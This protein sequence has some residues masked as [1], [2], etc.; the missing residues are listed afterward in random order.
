MG[1]HV[2]FVHGTI[3]RRQVHNV[4]D[5]FFGERKINTLHAQ[6]FDIVLAALVGTDVE[7]ALVRAVRR[8][9]ITNRLVV[10]FEER[11]V[12]RVVPSLG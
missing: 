10:N 8:Q 1:V 6:S 3:A 7:L 5:L 9:Q 12:E 4:F 11:D 2:G